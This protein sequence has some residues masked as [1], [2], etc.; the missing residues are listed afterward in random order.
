MPTTLLEK[1]SMPLGEV[2]AELLAIAHLNGQPVTDKTFDDS[3][4]AAQDDISRKY[5]PRAHPLVRYHVDRVAGETP[6][7]S[8]LATLE[9]PLPSVAVRLGL[10]QRF[11]ALWHSLRGCVL[12]DGGQFAKTIY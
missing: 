3:V 11:M 8:Q 9:P 6:C 4:W 12:Q 7:M 5:P 1:R 10:K 2:A